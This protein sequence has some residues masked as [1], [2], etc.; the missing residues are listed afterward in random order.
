MNKGADALSRRY[1]LLSVLESKVLSFEIIKGMYA[2]DEDLKE[3]YINSSS[4]P[5]GY[6]HVEDAFLFKGTRLCIPRCGFREL[7]IQELHGGAL[8][9]HCGVEKTCSMLKEHIIGLKCQ[10]MWST[11]LKGV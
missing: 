3:L 5:H 8:A 11:L 4:H 10:R 7:L 1:L 9:N 6:F 2:H